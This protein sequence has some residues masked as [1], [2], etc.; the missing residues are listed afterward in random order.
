M[1]LHEDQIRE[2]AYLIWERQGRPEGQQDEHW[3]QASLEVATALGLSEVSSAQ[4]VS[5]RRSATGP[6][7]AGPAG[8]RARKS[9]SLPSGSASSTV[10]SQS[11]SAR[12]KYRHPESPEL[13]W[14][15]RG[16]RPVWIRAAL[17]AGQRLADF[18]VPS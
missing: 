15:G 12:P 18:E 14:S 2:R 6:S 10:A 4:K 3:K 13:T 5:R 8:G 11:T 17:E 7:P 1:Y 16:R 9:S